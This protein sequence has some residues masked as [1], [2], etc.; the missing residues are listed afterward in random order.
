MSLEQQANSRLGE[1]LIGI[2]GACLLAAFFTWLIFVWSPSGHSSGVTVNPPQQ[3]VGHVSGNDLR[4]GITAVEVTVRGRKVPCVYVQQVIA[5]SNPAVSITC[6][7]S[8]DQ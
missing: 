6:D 5:G 4:D 3:T 8:R 2:G 1:W 7:W